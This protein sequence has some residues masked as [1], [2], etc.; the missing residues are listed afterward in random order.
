MTDR[1]R[2]AVAAVRK[3]LAECER[4][5][6]FSRRYGNGKFVAKVM[7]RPPLELP[8]RG[9]TPLW[10]SPSSLRKRSSSTARVMDFS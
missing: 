8:T 4:A 3:W 6:R 9:A 5:D 2:A 10:Q 7:K 1:D